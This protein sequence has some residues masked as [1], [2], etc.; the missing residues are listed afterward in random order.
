M[1][2]F[3]HDCL[4][5]GHEDGEYKK[6][7]H[8]TTNNPKPKQKKAKRRRPPPPQ[9]WPKDKPNDVAG[10][11]APQQEGKGDK[12]TAIDYGTDHF[13]PLSMSKAPPSKPTTQSEKGQQ[14]KVRS[15]QRNGQAGQLLRRGQHFTWCNKRDGAER[16]YSHIDWAFGNLAWLTQCGHIEA[17]FIEPGCFD[18]S[19][20]VVNTVNSHTQFRGRLKEVQE[21]ITTNLFDQA[22]ITEEREILQAIEL[23]EA[24]NERVLKQKSRAIWINY[25]D[26]NSKYFFAHLKARQARNRIS[27]IYNEQGAKL[28]DPS[29]IQQ[30]LMGVF[31]DTTWP[32]SRHSLL[33]KFTEEDVLQAVRGLPAD[34]SPGIDGFNAEFFKSH[35]DTLG[36]E[37]TDS[38]L[39]FFSFG[40][41]LKGVNITT[42]TLVPKVSAPTH[43]KEYRP[44]ACCTTLY[45][46]IS[47]ILTAKLKTVVDHIVSP[48]QS[49]FIEGRNILDNVI[50]A[51]EL[52]KEH[53]S[54]VLGLQA[55]LEKSSIYIAGVENDF[56]EQMLAD[57]HLSLGDLP[58]KYLGVPLSTKK[59]S[60]HQCLPIV[61]RMI[62]RVKCWSSK[63]L[64]YSGRMQL[65]NSVL[66]EM[67]TYWAQIFLL[68]KK[69]ISMVTTVC[70]TFLW[71]DSNNLSRKALVAWEKICK[72]KTAGG[73][74]V[75]DISTWNN[76]AIYKLLWAVEQKKDKLWVVWIHTF[77]IKA[78]DLSTMATPKQGYWL[79][80]KVF[81][82]RS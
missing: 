50:I 59:L 6:E 43:V 5:L 10:P 60:I 18:H 15:P 47:K 35:W 64:S 82:S 67:Q 30:E 38:I 55:N 70:R 37:V 68:P 42:V 25:G 1:P 75:L 13:P 69:I 4:Q 76:P 41:L 39:Q 48:S 62:S 7:Q 44:I 49:T 33:H 9:W 56:K 65:V 21:E 71:T 72:P 17:D 31:S 52:V 8:P 57:L 61:E 24:I 53:F 28:M 12:G 73:L 2:R 27:S 66:F 79:V 81:D 77:Y 16:I 19:H 29:L 54:E 58:F 80:R 78:N 14:Q 63:L 34:K 40:K 26:N 45:K 46:I 36:R 3:C 20:I 11:S 51:H 74:N 22:L 23:W 32:S